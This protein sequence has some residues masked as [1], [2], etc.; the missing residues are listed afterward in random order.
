MLLLVKILLI[1][2]KLMV[3]KFLG[4]AEK[5][6]IIIMIII[7]IFI[8]KG[9]CKKCEVTINNKKFLA[10][11]TKI[12]PIEEFPKNKIIQILIPPNITNK[13]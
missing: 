6:V 7:F 1:L 10:C 2:Q 8:F 9:E 3:L 5:V 12:P 4:L 11:K 13:K